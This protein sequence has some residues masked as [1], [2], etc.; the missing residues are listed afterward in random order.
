MKLAMVRI[1]ILYSITLVMKY[2]E[3]QV[4]FFINMYIKL[5]KT[6]NITKLS[7]F[8]KTCFIT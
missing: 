6:R 4:Y 7:R 2:F 5:T 8:E 1:L 3:C